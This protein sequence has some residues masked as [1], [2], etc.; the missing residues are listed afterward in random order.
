MVRWEG[1]GQFISAETIPFPK[2]AFREKKS[3]GVSGSTQALYLAEQSTF[4][5]GLIWIFLNNLSP[6]QECQ[7]QDCKAACS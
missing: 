3:T 2:R 5:L 6:C 7:G 1:A 4:R